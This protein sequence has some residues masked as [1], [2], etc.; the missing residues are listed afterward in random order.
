MSDLVI[1]AS[2]CCASLVAIVLIVRQ[3]V[4]E[5]ARYQLEIAKLEC[6]A[7]RSSEMRA[8]RRGESGPKQAGVGALAGDIIGAVAGSDMGKKLIEDAI[9]GLVKPG[10][11]KW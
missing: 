11:F 6:A 2:I 3:T 4:V 5:R 10:G 8:V 9:K 7:E 1:I